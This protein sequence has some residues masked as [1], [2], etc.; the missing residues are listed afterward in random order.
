[1]D[2]DLL[3][4]LYDFSPR[5]HILAIELL[6][7]DRLSFLNFMRYHFLHKKFLPHIEL[8][9]QFIISKNKPLL[10]KKYRLTKQVS[11]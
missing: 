6:K 10:A 3:I 1:M 9:G 11:L 4:D 5:K 8:Y 2:R 7:T